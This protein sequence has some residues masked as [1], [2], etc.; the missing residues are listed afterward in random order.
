MAKFCGKIGFEDTVETAPGVWSPG[1][2][3][4]TY[5]GDI[6]RQSWRTD[7]TQKINDDIVI[8]N[9][10]SVIADAYATKNIGHMKYVELF[11]SKWK[12]S[13]AEVNY[14]RIIINLGGVYNVD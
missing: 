1:C 6:I 11:G 3:E 4:F 9:Q 14:P 8:S 10:I 2:A 5:Y 13:S 12:I 7:G